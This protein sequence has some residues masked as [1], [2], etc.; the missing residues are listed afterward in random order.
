MNEHSTR[1]PRIL[2]ADDQPDVIEALRI[3]LRNEGYTVEAASSPSAVLDALKLR[4]FD[5][6]LIDLNYARDTTSGR[7]GIDLLSRIQALD[8]APPTIVM[9]GWGS[10]EVAVDAMRHG[11]REFI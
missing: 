10:V 4:S 5:T 6:V 7:E 3:L 8:F 9:T 2:I 1:N 11:A